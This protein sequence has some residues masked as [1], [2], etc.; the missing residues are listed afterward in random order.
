MVNLA[1]VLAYALMRLDDLP[2]PKASNDKEEN[3]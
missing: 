2:L 3:V 1:K